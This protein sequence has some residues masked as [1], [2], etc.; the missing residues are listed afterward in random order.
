MHCGLVQACQGPPLH[1]GPA[2]LLQI[3]AKPLNST[4]PCPQGP[5]TG[6]DPTSAAIVASP[7]DSSS[8]DNHDSSSSS[9]SVVLGSSSNVAAGPSYPATFIDPYHNAAVLSHQ[10]VMALVAEN[11]AADARLAGSKAPG[12]PQLRVLHGADATRALLCRLLRSL[13][14]VRALAPGAVLVMTVFA[15]VQDIGRQRVC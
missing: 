13:R 5:S 4:G 9:T 11:L 1:A 3:M 15:H 2:A 8:K 6:A 14:C 12:A 7:A 10:Q